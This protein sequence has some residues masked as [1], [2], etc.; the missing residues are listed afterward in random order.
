MTQR[1]TK[2][3]WEQRLHGT[4]ARV[5]DD[6]RKLLDYINDE[7]VPD[8]RKSGSEALRAAAQELNRLAQRIDERRGGKHSSPP[9]PGEAPKP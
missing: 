7:I 2:Y 1:S 3:A 5:E 6:L 9:P 8:V 4:G